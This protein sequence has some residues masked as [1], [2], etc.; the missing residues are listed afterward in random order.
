MNHNLCPM[1]YNSEQGRGY[2]HHNH[3]VDQIQK[4]PLY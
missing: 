3:F 4:A 2:Y 1:Q